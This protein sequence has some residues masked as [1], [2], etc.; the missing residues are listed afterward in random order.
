VNR[1]NG[2]IRPFLLALLLLA[3]ATLLHAQTHTL[4]PELHEKMAAKN[5]AIDGQSIDV[6]IQFRR[7]T[8][9]DHS[10]RQSLGPLNAPESVKMY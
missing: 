6:I 1:T 10:H 8:A 3:P 2:Y 5:H 7:G 9:L 4:A